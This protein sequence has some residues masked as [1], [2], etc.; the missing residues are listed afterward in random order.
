MSRIFLSHSSRDNRQAIALRQWLVE[1]DR[2]LTNDIFLDL[3]RDVGIKAGERWQEALRRANTRCEAV[4]CLLSSNW[5]SS[6]YC[7]L[8][9][10][11]ARQL[12]KKI[13]CARLEPTSDGDITADFQHCDLFGDGAMTGI[14]IGDGAPVAFT[15]DGLYRLRAGILA[16]GVGANSFEWPPATDP[17]RAP[18]R[19]WDPLDHDD[20]AVFFGRDAEILAG[21]DALRGMRA[22][23]VD[24]LFVVQGPSGT[25]KSSFLRAGLLPRLR[26]DDRDFVLLDIVRPQRDVL[27]S[28]TGLAQSIHATR[29][30]LGLGGPTLLDVKRACRRGEA[31]RLRAWLREVQATASG[32]LLAAP[33]EAA[34]PTLVLPVDQAEELFSVDAGDEATVF[35]EL[36]AGLSQPVDPAGNDDNDDNDPASRLGLI[37][38]LTIRTDR[39]EELKKAPQLDGVGRVVFDQ[40]KPMPRTQFKDVITGPAARATQARRPLTIDPA[41]VSQLL[42]DCTEGSDAL[43]L[44]ALTLERLFEDC[45]HEPSAHDPDGD[46]EAQQPAP[47]LTLADYAS[48]G[49]VGHVV[50]TEIDRILS[51]DPEQRQHE[52][53]LLRA[54]FIPWLATINPD[55]D[56]PLRR[57]ARWTDLPEP[58]RPLLEKLIERRLLV[59]DKRNDEVVV[60]VALE[61]LLRQWDD[62]CAWLA[63]ER[64]DLKHA[65]ALDRDTTAWEASGRDDAWLLHGTRLADA[66]NLLR[67]PGFD[68]HLA[69]TRDYVQVSRQR[70]DEQRNNELREAQAHAEALEKRSTTLRRVLAATAVIAVIAVVAAVIAV[71]N[72]GKT[73]EALNQSQKRYYQATAVRLANDGEAI[74]AGQLPGSDVQGLQEILAAQILDPNYG[75]AIF[76]AAVE[77]FSTVKLIDT[78]TKVNFTAI[79]PD[80]RHLATSSD[81]VKVRFWSADTGRQEGDPVEGGN[82]I[83]YSPDGTLLAAGRGKGKGGSAQLWNSLT[84]QHIRTLTGPTGSTTRIVVSPHGDLVAAGDG[85]GTAWIWN[86][87]TGAVLHKLTVDTRAEADNRAVYGIAFSPTMPMLA[88]GGTDGVVRTWN[89]DTGALIHEFGNQ[90]LVESLSFSPD[91]NTLAVGGD[92]KA[93]ALIDPSDGSIKYQDPAQPPL[94]QPDPVLADAFSPVGSGYPVMSVGSN[95]TVHQWGRWVGGQTLTDRPLPGKAGRVQNLAFSADG[96]RLTAGS[97]DGLLRLWNP[98]LGQPEFATADASDIQYRVAFDGTGAGYASSELISGVITLW[99]STTGLPAGT[100]L[101][102]GSAV[103]GMAFRPGTQQL[104]VAVKDALQLWDANSRKLVSTLHPSQ[105]PLGTLAVSRDGLIAAT[106]DGGDV[107]IW[108]ADTEARTHLLTTH[109]DKVTGVNFSGDGRRLAVIG[110]VGTGKPDGSVDPTVRIFEPASGAPIT[111]IST[112]KAD[113]VALNPDGHRLVTGGIDGSVLLWNTDTGKLDH[114]QPGHI[115]EVNAVAFSPDGTYIAS[116]GDDSSLRMSDAASGKAIGKS[117]TMVYSVDSLAFSPDGRRLVTGGA[118]VQLWPAVASAQDLCDKLTANMSPEQWQHWVAPDIPYQPTCP[119][120]R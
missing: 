99:S 67:K 71:V 41:L 3:H 75:S 66:E 86:T 32:R 72:T 48:M 85:D 73:R 76:D 77:R 81:D 115:G 60:E 36:I 61:S 92:L 45:R 97:D 91:G 23:R 78:G 64:D 96:E 47:H 12:N 82:G 80:G 15:S 98:T 105:G 27:T 44:L 43:P 7:R 28:N 24:T 54:A 38:A 16:A 88:T 79:S 19:G 2:R 49:G 95:G 101:D 42:E 87:A 31:E 53:E 25:G 93:V 84:H 114:T 116:G 56:E 18:Y 39:Y 13:I 8:E 20:A 11:T 9:F 68:E 6:D 50:H 35:L 4:V 74:L 103:E 14:D 106:G 65:D 118:S 70:E 37:V 120:L 57:I 83:A 111:S 117:M 112:P 58:S 26:R 110:Y 107:E 40:L 102:T 113:R 62:L 119:K 94:V 5:E 29:I 21:L 63:E 109:F 1:Q 10:L 33:A 17:D 104:V 55:N 52:L 59:R 108:N 69:R 34:L 90:G 89:T 100:P 30:H 51:R 22:A 46:P